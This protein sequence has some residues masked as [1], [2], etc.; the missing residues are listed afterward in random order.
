MQ[1]ISYIF[2]MGI[3]VNHNWPLGY[4]G[5]FEMFIIGEQVRIPIVAKLLH[6]CYSGLLRRNNMVLCD[7]LDIFR[8]V[9]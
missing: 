1:F 2:N 5:R 4:A 9:A 7:I 3:V 8:G 6:F